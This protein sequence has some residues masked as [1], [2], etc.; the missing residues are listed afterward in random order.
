MG[1]IRRILFKIVHIKLHLI[2]VAIIIYF[3]L[4]I[5]KW[6]FE[7]R[8]IWGV[9]FF[10]TTTIVQLLKDHWVAPYALWHYAGFGGWPVFTYPFLH[11]Y[12]INFL[13]PYFDVIYSVQLWM[14]VSTALFIVGGYF[15]FF[16]ISRN[17]FIATILAVAVAYSS[18]VY[19][20]LTWA[21]SLPSYATQAVFPWILG[22][23]AL[24]FRTENMRYFLAAASLAGISILGHPLVFAG[25]IVPASTIM[26]FARFNKGL[27]IFNKFKLW[28]SFLAIAFLI[29][30]PQFSITLESS[31]KSVFEK[32]YKA[33]ETTTVPVS[34]TQIDIANFNKNQVER[35]YTDNHT[36]PFFITG[37]TMLLFFISFFIGHKKNSILL[38]IPYLAVAGY[39]TFYIWLFGQGISIYHGGWYR[40]FWSVPI[41]VGMLASIFWFLT[42]SHIKHFFKHSPVGVTLSVSLNIMVVILG[43]AALSQFQD[44]KAIDRIIFRSQASSAHPDVL[45][46]RVTDQER[47]QLKSKLI[48]SWLDSNNTNY[49]IY[50][51]DQTVNIWWNSLYKMP[52]ARGYLDAPADSGYIF[53]LDS[54]LSEDE[55]EPQLVKSFGYPLETVNS[56]TQFLLDWYSIKYYEGGHE[57]DVY[58]PFPRYLQSLVNNEE[59]VDLNAEKYNK[60]NEFLRF[61]DIKD[62]FVSPILTATNASTIGIFA[63]DQGFGTVIRAIAERGNLNSQL[64]IPVKLGRK[65]D[66]YERSIL[67]KLDAIYLYDY[68]YGTEG[69]AFELL[70]RLAESGKKIFI[71]TGVEVKQSS[72]VMPG[73]FPVANTQRRGMGKV[74]S[75]GEFSPEISKEVDFS[76]FAPPVFDDDEWKIS[77][78][79]SSDL[80]E[81]VRVLLKNQDKVIMASRKVG[82]GEIIW[83][84]MNLAY[85][86]I[87]NHNQ[88][89]SKLFNN[90]LSQLITLD[91][92]L[93]PDYSTEFINSNRRLIHT[94]GAKGIL[95]KEQAYA[96]WM[97][98]AE[99]NGKSI[100]L[101]ILKAGPANPG[102][103]YIPLPD[104]GEYTVHLTYNGS[105]INKLVILV[106]L[107]VAGVLFEEIVL[108]GVFLGRARKFIWNKSKLRM[109]KWWEK[110]EE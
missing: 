95:F 46:L 5:A 110:E 103:M 37:I 109:A 6:Y 68:D 53:W 54:A 88:E 105:I 67:K 33:I 73:I 24:Y 79:D 101:K 41:W 31:L 77:Y 3:F 84:G 25:Y 65:I 45:N 23:L 50:D 26:I 106:P 34:Q 86:V 22:F 47:Q 94:N 91:K 100:N 17:F 9:D 52:L 60:R 92:K 49:R 58:K 1:K 35:I 81:D 38:I 61:F 90:I 98:K 44:D 63:S 57:G 66:N 48:P 8:P 64:I 39:F 75:L 43:L 72:G 30:L 7:Y 15:L 40:L 80:R 70:L 108:F 102:F 93:T 89:E 32:S 55:G 59:I 14:M 62:D 78:A 4:P 27:A 85:H 99:S 69:R 56:N 13:T 16:I 21:G 11:F 51:G 107:I 28:L 10:L 87:R 29:G 19:Q 74:W 42:S 12:L 18:G 71:E 36:V 82:E 20:T 104:I 96:G 83:S 76:L 2:C 97:A